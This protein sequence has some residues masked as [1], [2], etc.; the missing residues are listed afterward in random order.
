M[1]RAKDGPFGPH[2]LAWNITSPTT[3]WHT[4]HTFCPELSLLATRLFRTPVSR[5]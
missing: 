5:I 3:F 2:Y 1:Y 4:Q